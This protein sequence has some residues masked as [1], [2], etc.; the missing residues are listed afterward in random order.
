[1]FQFLLIT[2]VFLL[3]CYT[4]NFSLASAII[5]Y[6]NH[7]QPKQTKCREEDE[8]E[9]CIVYRKNIKNK[10]HEKLQVNEKSLTLKT[11]LKKK[12]KQKR[13]RINKNKTKN[14]TL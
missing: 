5:E 6:V 11:T 13:F 14:I 2:L 3:L 1:M 9:P 7:L 10:K 8:E 4:F 12:Y